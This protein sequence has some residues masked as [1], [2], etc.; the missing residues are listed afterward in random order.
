ME[1]WIVNSLEYVLLTCLPPSS[2]ETLSNPDFIGPG[3]IID[4]MA[5]TVIQHHLDNV[6]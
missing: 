5:V 3:A 4:I 1:L 2:Y 6:A